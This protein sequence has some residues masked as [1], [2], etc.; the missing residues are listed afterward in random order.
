MKPSEPRPLRIQIRPATLADFAAI[1]TMHRE[2]HVLHRDSHLGETVRTASAYHQFDSVLREDLQHLLRERAAFVFVAH[3]GPKAAGY[4]TGKVREE[5]GRVLPRRGFME[6]W[7]VE[8]QYRRTG[9]GRALVLR[10]RDA[11]KSAGCQVFESSTWASNEGARHAHRSLGF[12]EAQVSYRL[13]LN[14]VD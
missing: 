10:L 5:P 1:Y 13:I 14:D 11:F 2:L 12:E 8:P 4:V 3:A 7:W 6:D 9:L